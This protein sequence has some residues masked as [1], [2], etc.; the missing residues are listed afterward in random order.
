MSFT[1]AR[2]LA[3][4]RPTESVDSQCGARAG[5][6]AANPPGFLVG[7]TQLISTIQL[8]GCEAAVEGILRRHFAEEAEGALGAGHEANVRE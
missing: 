5:S 7:P 2:S 4:G 3:T 6:S 8:E 1:V